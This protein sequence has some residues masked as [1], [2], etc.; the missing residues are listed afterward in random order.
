MSSHHIVREKQ[1]PA[2]LALS[3]TDFSFEHLGQLLE[4]SPTV[5]A[6]DDTFHYF[7][8]NDIKVD[9]LITSEEADQS[10][11]NIRVIARDAD[12]LNDALSIL[13][14]EGYPAVNIVTDE[15]PLLQAYAAYLSQINLVFYT[16]TEKIYPVKPGFEKWKAAGEMIRLL[17]PVDNLVVSGLKK[18]DEDHYQTVA[19]GF[20]SLN[21]SAE[22]I[23][24]A[25]KI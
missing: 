18:I 8:A 5:I 20:F 23:F 10:Q 7:T 4:W 12:P 13:V 16:S 19:D 11:R 15:M 17:S 25:E 14:Q 21:F 1:E 6:T 9:W 22:F 3:L 2:L 24:I